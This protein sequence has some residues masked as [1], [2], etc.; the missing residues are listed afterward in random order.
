MRDKNVSTSVGSFH[1][2]GKWYDHRIYCADDDR[3]ECLDEDGN[4][5]LTFTANCHV[6]DNDKQE[7]GKWKTN[8]SYQWYVKLNNQKMFSFGTDLLEAEMEVSKMY[9]KGELK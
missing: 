7:L 5:I 1:L 8:N 3:V 6:L 2:N 9:I 4:V